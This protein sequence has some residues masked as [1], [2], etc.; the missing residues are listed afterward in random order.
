MAALAVLSAQ[1]TVET[2]LKPPLVGV[3]VGLAVF[4]YLV[5]AVA[6]A[7]LA[8]FDAV[9]RCQ[10]W[11]RWVTLSL[12]FP[13]AVPF[14]L[15]CVR[16]PCIG[17]VPAPLLVNEFGAMFDEL[18]RA[19]TRRRIDQNLP[20]V[21]M[22]IAEVAVAGARSVVMAQHRLSPAEGEQVATLY[23]RTRG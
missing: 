3:E 2:V 22:A 8:G 13:F 15:L 4:G 21:G 18:V 7:A 14:V 6:I 23:A 20:L 9:S 1:A 19:E 11:R 10:P 12:L 16:V 17:G 5:V